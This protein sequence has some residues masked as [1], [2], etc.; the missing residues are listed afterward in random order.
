MPGPPDCANLPRQRPNPREFGADGRRVAVA[1]VDGRLRR[2][3][4]EAGEGGAHLPLV[5]A[6][7]VNAAVAVREEGV[8]ADQSVRRRLEEDDAARRVT[9]R[10]PDG[11]DV[12]A[13]M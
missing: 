7:D 6:G 12:V 1:G 2:Q 9:R 13:E 5:R 8:P 10:V 11:E 3:R 4:G